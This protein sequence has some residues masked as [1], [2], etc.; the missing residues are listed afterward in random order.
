ML[1]R[2]PVRQL[3]RLASVC[4]LIVLALILCNDTATACFGQGGDPLGGAGG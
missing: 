2:Q 1:L 4:H 3:M